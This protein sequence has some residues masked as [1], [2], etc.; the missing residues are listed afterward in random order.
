MQKSQ[1]YCVIGFCEG[2]L[3]TGVIMFK[4][5]LLIPDSYYISWVFVIPTRRSPFHRQHAIIMWYL[6][7]ELHYSAHYPPDIELSKYSIFLSNDFGA[8]SVFYVEPVLWLCLEKETVMNLQP[9]NGE[10]IIEDKIIK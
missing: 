10:I 7:V 8:R 4:K 2:N 3:L 9:G 5:L 1:I 6:K